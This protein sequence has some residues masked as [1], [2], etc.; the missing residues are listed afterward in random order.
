MADGLDELATFV[1]V[2]DAGSIAGAARQLG[3]PK[4]TVSRRISRLEDRLGV[5][6]LQRTT[7]SM[8]ATAE[9][10][11]LYQRASGPLA[12]LE[13]AT[14]AVAD[15]GD[16]PRGLLRITAP[17][18]FGRLFAPIVAEFMQKYPEVSVDVDLTG[19]K[20]DLVA[21][22]FDLAV[23]G[24]NL[25][26][27]SLIARKL[28]VVELQLFAS[29]AYLAEHGT[30][31]KVADLVEHECILFRPTSE[32]QQW[33]FAGGKKAEAVQVSGRLR[34]SEF[35][36]IRTA[37]VAGAGIARMPSHLGTMDVRDGRLLRVLPK[38]Y[39]NRGGLSLMYPSAR[40]LPAKAR[41]FRDHLIAAFENAAWQL[42]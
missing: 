20:V 9:G 24:G 39:C 2:V 41:A 6:L 21:E 19:R 5:R 31:K 11:G 42:G 17:V 27:S 33:S 22:G 35:A 38:R 3:V 28:A 37:C 10:L 12:D 23:R 1:R 32:S 13:N 18:D 14:S 25:E 7:R 36:F 16:T 8:R 29:P 34:S 15:A 26:D 40:H 4:S 30:P